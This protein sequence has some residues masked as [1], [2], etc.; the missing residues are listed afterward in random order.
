MDRNGDRYVRDIALILVALIGLEWN[1][2]SPAF[3]S[4]DG[5]QMDLQLFGLLLLGAVGII[6]RVYRTTRQVC[7]EIDADAAKLRVEE[8]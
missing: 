6:R 8:G 3:Q 5:G 1:T 2:R 4:G 7:N